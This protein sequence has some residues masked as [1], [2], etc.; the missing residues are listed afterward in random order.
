MP[1][2]SVDP[3]KCA[4]DGACIAVCPAGIIEF[5][6][7]GAKV[8]ALV[9]G[10]ESGCIR[11][12]HCVAVC[13][14]GAL[15]HEAMGPMDCPPVREEF[16]V[17]PEVMEH[18]IRSR[19]S[20]RAY[21]KQAVPKERLEAAIDMARYAP[22]GVN[23]QPVNWLV[24]M[25]REKVKVLAGLVA[26][27]M[28]HL[29]AE[30]SPLAEL[31]GFERILAAWNAGKDRILRGAPHLVAVHA[32]SEDRTAPAA[33]TI[34]L[35]YF[36]LAAGSLGLGTCWAGYF[37]TAAGLSKPLARELA[38]ADGH[39]VLGAMMVGYSR[40]SYKRLPLRNPA[41]ITWR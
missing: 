33:C 5:G 13:P 2:I 41:R 16:H 24:V 34:A 39:V 12:G 8:P 9:P 11:C 32:R 26:D 31:L 14:E 3:E 1:M 19:R 22:S 20:V 27:W 25:D 36:D 23:L 30:K 38:L 15:T 29:A 28:K 6:K 37:T 17:G 10:M 35:S 4:G 18:V 7:E 40:F 21:R